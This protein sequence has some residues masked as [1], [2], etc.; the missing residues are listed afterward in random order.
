MKEYPQFAASADDVVALLASQLL[1]RI[2]TIDPDKIPRVGLHVFIHDGLTV[3]MH[4]ATDDAQLEDVRRGSPVVIEVDETLST[5][6]SHWID[7]AN[8]TNADQFYR[9]ASLWGTTSIV[10]D[11]DAIATHLRGI[12]AK[13]Q[14]EG[15]HSAVTA[16]AEYYREAIAYLNVVRVTGTSM[17]TKFKLGQS[18]DPAK[19]EQILA[20]LRERGG[21]L[22]GRT[23]ALISDAKARVKD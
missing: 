22:D 10:T 20:R 2:V 5:S 17:R 15:R 8:A 11:P 14:P 6:P 1:A 16:S 7:E 21:P 18:T 3:E 12:L 9:C 4:F 19:R 23:A 13:Y